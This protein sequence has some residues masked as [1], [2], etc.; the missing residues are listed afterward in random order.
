MK[1]ILKKISSSKIIKILFWSI[2]CVV[3]IFEFGVFVFFQWLMFVYP[4]GQGIERSADLV[5][6][7]KNLYYLSA[8]NSVPMIMI[9]ILAL[10]IVVIYKGKV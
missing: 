2:F 7:S 3:N 6:F 10:G 4:V 1:K 8:L 9:N 5:E